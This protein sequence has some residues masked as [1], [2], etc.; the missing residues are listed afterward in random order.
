MDTHTWQSLA[1]IV[2]LMAV[3]VGAGWARYSNRDWHNTTLA[4]ASGI[5]VA[6]VFV[7]LLPEVAAHEDAIAAA[8]GQPAGRN[9]FVVTLLGVLVFLAVDWA[10]T[11]RRREPD[12]AGAGRAV[13]VFSVVS[14]V[15]FNLLLG[16]VI[17]NR[18]G[19]EVGP[20]ALLTIAMA[21]HFYVND[22][23]LTTNHAESFHLVGRWVLAAALLLGWLLGLVVEVSEAVVGLVVA[24]L[25]GGVI[26]RVLRNEA[27]GI[28]N[29]EAFVAGAVG[30]ALLLLALT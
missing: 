5:A 17:G 1:A 13:Y 19:P 24:F 10:S 6:Y 11:R 12:T 2:V 3:H 15:L 18:A 16:Y 9:V 4:A 26:V 27:V 29:L 23:A 7:Q 30:Y 22:H 8:T 25:G 20:L 28:D 21:V 14:Y